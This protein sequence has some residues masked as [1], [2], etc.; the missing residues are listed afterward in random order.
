M[1]PPVEIGSGKAD[2]NLSLKIDWRYSDIRLIP[3]MG[4]IELLVGFGPRGAGSPITP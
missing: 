2:H 3:W 4:E 1:K